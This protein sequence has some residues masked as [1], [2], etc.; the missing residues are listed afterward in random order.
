[1]V[2][3]LEPH[4]FGLTLP[5]R[6]F[7]SQ[8]NPSLPNRYRIITA[9]AGDSRIVAG[10]QTLR[11]NGKR[12]VYVERLTFDHSATTPEEGEC[13]VHAHGHSLVGLSLSLSSQLLISL[14]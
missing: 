7:V 14:S 5:T 9:N 4:V 3:K 1:M 8:R 6:L 2:I 13:M 10:V 12:G 11:A